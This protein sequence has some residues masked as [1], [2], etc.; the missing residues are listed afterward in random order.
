MSCQLLADA[1]LRSTHYDAISA[2]TRKQVLQLLGNSRFDV[3]LI[4]PNFFPDPLE[5][6]RFVREARNLHPQIGIIVLLDAMERRLVVEAF[7]CGARGLFCRS[8]SFQALCKCIDCVQAGQVWAGGAELEFL[9][10]ALVEPVPI[11]THG[12]PGVRPLSR[13]EEEIARLV[14]EGCSN[15]QISQRLHLSE[16]TIKNY[17]FRVFE[18]LGVSTRVE[19]TLYA[20]KRGNI[21]RSRPATLKSALGTGTRLL[22][23]GSSGHSG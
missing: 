1:L 17:L 23:T 5:G 13:R 9:L 15:R 3:L 19:L 22:E 14:A 2:A 16:H 4:S 8:D 6:V 21:P 12:L 10:Q 7:R 20:L 11:E 18:K